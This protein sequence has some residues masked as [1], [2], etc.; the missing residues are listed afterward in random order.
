M[1]TILLRIA[2]RRTAWE[3]ET[4]LQTRIGSEFR[5]RDGA[6]DLRPSVYEVQ[7]DPSSIIRA[8]AEHSANAGLD[9]PRGGYN[10]DLSGRRAAVAPNDSGFRFTREAHRELSFNSEDDLREFVIDVCKNREKYPVKK[11]EMMSYVATRIGQQD[12]E[13]LSFCKASPKKEGWGCP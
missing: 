4:D 2:K 3:S 8:Y 6:I 7:P 13:W 10:L 1:P 11:A 5:T 9:P 12:D